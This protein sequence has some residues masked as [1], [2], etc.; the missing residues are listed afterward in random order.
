MLAVQPNEGRRTI[1][2]VQ[3]PIFTSNVPVPPK[4][5][6]PGNI[7]N[8]WKQWKQVWRAFEIVTRL[9]EQ[10]DGLRYSAKRN[11]TKQ[12]E[13][14]FITPARVNVSYWH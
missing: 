6:L 7:A 2:A 1:Q 11:E 10:T 12:D 14:E 13:K 4:I 9:N 3:A 8:N 5:E